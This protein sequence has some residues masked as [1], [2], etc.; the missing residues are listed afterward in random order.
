MERFRKG[1]WRR[2][3]DSRR[4]KHYI[5]EINYLSA[6]TE[7]NFAH[8]FAQSDALSDTLTWQ[9]RTLRYVSSMPICWI[10]MIPAFLPTRLAWPHKKPQDRKPTQS[11]PTVS[12][13]AC[14]HV[15]HHF[16]IRGTETAL[17]ALHNMQHYYIVVASVLLAATRKDMQPITEAIYD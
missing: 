3:P 6:S 1:C 4:N 7:C 15:S 2:V 14:P 11:I 13:F 12:P 16:I 8:V 17:S 5:H 10:C 9:R